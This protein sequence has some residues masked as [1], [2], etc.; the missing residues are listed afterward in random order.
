MFLF[1]LKLHKIQTFCLALFNW[2]VLIWST[3]KYTVCGLESPFL[4]RSAIISCVGQ[5][6]RWIFF[7][8][9]ASGVWWKLMSLYF[10]CK[11]YDG[12]F[13]S[14]IVP[15]L[16]S[17]IVVDFSWSNIMPLS[18]VCSHIAPCFAF[19]KATCSVSVGE[20]VTTD[21]RFDLMTPCNFQFETCKWK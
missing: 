16:S 8:A 13:T 4:S 9:T 12:F 17:N 7:V 1:T 2:F 10:V 19:D 11:Q 5:Y 6:C 21:W 18:K 14:S 15:S 20:R 3:Y